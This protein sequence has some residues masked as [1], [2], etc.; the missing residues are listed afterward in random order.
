MDALKS[1]GQMLDQIDLEQIPRSG[2]DLSYNNK[3]TC[4]VGRIVPTRCMEMMPGDSVKGSTQVAM[5]FEPL[6]VPILANMRCKQE[7]WYVPNHILWDNWDEFYTKGEDLSDIS[8]VP[9]V[10]LARIMDYLSRVM[11]GYY[12]DDD[13]FFY[14]RAGYL[15]L[16]KRIN[17]A[18]LGSAEYMA[19]A[20]RVS[21]LS[22]NYQ[23]AVSNVKK[24]YTGKDLAEA[25][26]DLK[27]D[28]QELWDL[29]AQ[30][31]SMYGFVEEIKEEHYN[32]FL[33][34]DELLRY[35]SELEKFLNSAVVQNNGLED[36]YDY[37]RDRI[38]DFKE[39]IGT[40]PQYWDDRYKGY[41]ILL[42][43]D[44][45][46]S[47][48]A[49]K[50]AGST[51]YNTLS[52]QDLK[53]TN[54]VWRSSFS[55]P[56]MFEPIADILA[57]PDLAT[58]FSLSVSGQTTTI[59]CYT[60]SMCIP[61]EF[62]TSFI[63][64]MYDLVSPLVGPSSTL[65][66]LGY[67]QLLPQDFA[68]LSIIGINLNIGNRSFV[69]VSEEEQGVGYFDAMPFHSLY[70]THVPKSILPLRAC[71]AIW[72]NN[73]RD[74]LLETDAP[75][76]VTQTV[77][78]D[79]ELLVLLSPRLR[80]WSKDAF[81]TSLANTG[82]GNMVVPISESLSKVGYNASNTGDVMEDKLQSI[83]QLNL[84]D[85]T[86]SD[87]TKVELPTRFLSSYA[88][89]VQGAAATNY[90]F[91]LDLLRRVGRAEKWVQ[92]ALI[93]GNKIQDAL[94]THWRVKIKN[95]RI[96]LPE[97][98]NSHVQTIKIDTILNNT[99]T[100][101]SNA[102]DKAG[103]ASMYGESN[104]FTLY[105]P[106]CG[107]LISFMSI[108][109]EQSYPYGTPR[110]LDRLDVFDFPFPEFAQIGMDAVYESELVCSPVSI[111]VNTN[112]V[113]NVFGY[114]GRYY[115]LKFKQDEEHGELLTTQNMYTFGREFSPYGQDTMPKLNARFVHC[116]PKLDM[117]VVDDPYIDLVRYDIHHSVAATRAFPV[118]GLSV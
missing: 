39:Y 22:A 20:T 46:T 38:K 61:S 1:N 17:S 9:S 26:R 41:V 110:H 91:S 84:A 117:F 7:D 56:S 13:H 10:T 78:T 67:P 43:Q 42:Y 62:L 90:S 48:I 18:K 50:V 97:F 47:L 72:Y 70:C 68:L 19:L 59:H 116:H 113:P 104:G 35:L 79:Q 2:F 75:K 64:L 94:F 16:N 82:T 12:P 92:K 77:I 111:N 3:G 66:Y 112:G 65:G 60:K 103:F 54:G 69:E 86:L 99:T 4:Q 100:A 23:N 109:P 102:G 95:E 25:M 88:S 63:R 28:Y 80:C 49:P 15:Y 8:K 93:Y 107:W 106:E 76:P 81:T 37:Y 101:E 24:T 40:V 33:Y 5:Q 29:Q 57:Q 36:L 11:F 118:C 105:S 55:L 45:E 21:Q 30:L 34:V 87:G 52:F 98:V 32:M 27:T 74:Q 89:D 71:Y 6:A 44:V 96:Q 58:N 31:K 85:Y 108:L 73:Y 83:M 114:Q 14:V 51:V 53:D 115:D